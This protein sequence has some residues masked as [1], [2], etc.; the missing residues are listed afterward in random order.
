MTIL[1]GV[2]ATIR[3]GAI[4]TVIGPNGAAS[5]QC[6]RL[7]GLLPARS[8]SIVFD[9]REV[10]GLTP[11]KMLDAGVSYVPQGRNIFPIVRRHNLELGASP[12]SSQSVLPARLEA[13]M[14]RFPMLRQKADAQAARSRA[15]SRS[16]SRSR[17]V[18]SWSRS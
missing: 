2:T 11:R 17:A 1:N 7:F 3:R 18:C 5:R 10:N 13:M 6:S 8:G 12:I 15:A 4:T 16:C 9:G 14:E